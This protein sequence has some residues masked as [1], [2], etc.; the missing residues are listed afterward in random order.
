MPRALLLREADQLLDRA[1]LARPLYVIGYV[2]A[3][4]V[5]SIALFALGKRLRRS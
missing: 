1:L 3:D 4:V 5:V 2:A